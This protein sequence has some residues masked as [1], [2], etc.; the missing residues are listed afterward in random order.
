M[1][2]LLLFS[3]MLRLRTTRA[4]ISA[5]DM[6]FFWKDVTNMANLLAICQE[7]RPQRTKLLFQP[8]IWPTHQT[9]GGRNSYFLVEGTV[10]VSRSRYH[11]RDSRSP[12]LEEG[13]TRLGRKRSEEVEWGTKR[14]SRGG[15]KL[16]GS[17]PPRNR[18]KR[19]TY[20]FWE[21]M[22]SFQTSIS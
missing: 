4:F 2:I 18:T 14:C 9:S 16:K 15:R 22:K 8:N 11:G 20:G 17:V 21:A 1:A 5:Q 12:R 6:V 10:R 19:S 7:K 3:L 13:R